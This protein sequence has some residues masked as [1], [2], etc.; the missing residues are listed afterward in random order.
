[1]S[2]IFSEAERHAVTTPLRVGDRFRLTAHG[3]R[4]LRPRSAHAGVILGDRGDSWKIAYDGVERDE[5]KVHKNLIQR[6]TDR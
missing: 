2:R 5:R 6:E 1:M 4:L 3:R